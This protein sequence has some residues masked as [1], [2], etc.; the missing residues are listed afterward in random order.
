M[1]AKL[2]TG[3]VLKHAVPDP[4]VT[5]GTTLEP[6]LAAERKRCATKSRPYSAIFSNLASI[7]WY[8]HGNHIVAMLVYHIYVDSK[9]NAKALF[10]DNSQ[11]DVDGVGPE[12]SDEKL[13]QAGQGDGS[14]KQT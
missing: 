5:L 10:C 13:G 9:K 11:G 1:V 6:R 2:T 3:V 12:E 7:L 4:I 8:W 14:L